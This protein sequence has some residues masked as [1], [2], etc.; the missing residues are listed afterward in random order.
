MGPAKP[1]AQRCALWT[2]PCPLPPGLRAPCSHRGPLRREH[3]LIPLQVGGGSEAGPHLYPS[4]VVPAAPP[5]RPVD[6]CRMAWHLLCPQGHRRD[7][8]RTS[9]TACQQLRPWGCGRQQGLCYPEPPRTPRVASR[10]PRRSHDG[11]Q[12]PL[13]GGRGVPLRC[14]SPVGP[15][16][17][18]A[19]RSPPHPVLRRPVHPTW[20]TRRALPQECW[21]RAAGSSPRPQLACCVTRGRPHLSEP[22]S[23]SVKRPYRLC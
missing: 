11:G 4:R 18:T 16:P 17:V 8:A 20:P 19:R 15:S 23:W 7:R 3:Q 5:A 14:M 12:R 9:S 6:G 2:L 1:P 21:G 13:P 22:L 10:A